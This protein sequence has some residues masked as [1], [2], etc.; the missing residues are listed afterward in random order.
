[1]EQTNS[2]A[3][4]AGTSSGGEASSESVGK[5]YYSGSV[6]SQSSSPRV[7]PFFLSSS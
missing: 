4:V 1:M 6:Y 7:K 5:N 2:K 3:K